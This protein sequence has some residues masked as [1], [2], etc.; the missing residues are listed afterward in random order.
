MPIEYTK[1]FAFAADLI[2]HDHILIL[3]P[4]IIPQPHSSQTSRSDAINF[5]GLIL[6]LLGLEILLCHDRSLLVIHAI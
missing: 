1:D 6:L 2:L 3:H 4:I 5:Q